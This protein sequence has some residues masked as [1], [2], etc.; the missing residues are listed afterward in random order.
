MIGGEKGSK[1]ERN[2]DKKKKDRE[3]YFFGRI[4]KLWLVV[5]RRTKRK[6]RRKEEEEEGGGGGT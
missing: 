4:E 6:K 2:I 1:V 5:R 3:V